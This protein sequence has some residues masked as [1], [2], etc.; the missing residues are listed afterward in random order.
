MKVKRIV[1]FAIY[2]YVLYFLGR[3]F[4]W[5][6]RLDGKNVPIILST[7]FSP[8]PTSLS[9]YVDDKLYISND[10]LQTMYES[11]RI[12]QSFGFHRLTVIVD[13]ETFEE[14]FWVFPVRWIY[15][16]VQKYEP[17]YK[18]DENWFYVRFSSTPTVLM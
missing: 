2:L 15:V 13:G 14:T 10:S 7:Q 5:Y 4:Y 9:L 3:G 16:E 17:N 18:E 6:Y 12:K 8:V 1:L 11:L